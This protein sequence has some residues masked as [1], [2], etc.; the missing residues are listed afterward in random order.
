MLRLEKM[1]RKM[2]QTRPQTTACSPNKIIFPGALI[3]NPPEEL[4]KDRIDDVCVLLL[5]VNGRE[6]DA[7]EL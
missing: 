5:A 6:D 4:D 3:Y 2:K 1:K 7:G